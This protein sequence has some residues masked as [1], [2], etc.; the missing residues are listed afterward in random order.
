[1]VSYH[2]ERERETERNIHIDMERYDKS[3][4]GNQKVEKSH[5]KIKSVL[6][7]KTWQIN[8][9]SLKLMN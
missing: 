6:F 3:G 5:Y 2:G 4:T 8:E 9:L 1:M 7:Q